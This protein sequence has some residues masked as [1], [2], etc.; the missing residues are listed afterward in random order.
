MPTEKC[1]Y[2]NDIPM[3]AEIAINWSTFQFVEFLTEKN[4]LMLFDGDVILKYKYG[5]RNF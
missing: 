1:E 4:C 2:L 5:N 3:L